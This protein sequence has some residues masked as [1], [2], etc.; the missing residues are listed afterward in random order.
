MDV[1]TFLQELLDKGLSFSTIKVYLA[2][3]SACHFGFDG[4]TPGAHLLAVRFWKES[5]G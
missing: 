4:V 2:A 3:I 5:A 1:L